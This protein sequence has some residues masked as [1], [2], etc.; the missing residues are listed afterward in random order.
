MLNYYRHMAIFTH[1]VDYGSISAASLALNLS[2]SVISQQLKSLEE[3][4]GVQLLQRTTRRQILTPAGQGFYR[5]CRSMLASSELAWSE[6][7]EAQNLPAGSIT[8]SAPHALIEGIIAPSIGELVSKYEKITPN[9][10]I[11]DKRVNL[12][13]DG[14]DLA[15]RV[16]QLP[17]SDYKQI[18]LG[19]FREVLCA[20]PKYISDNTIDITQLSALDYIANAWQ[21]KTIQHEAFHIHTGESQQFAFIANRFSN[22]LAA[23]VAMAKASTG[24]AFIPDFIFSQYEKEKQ[25]VN[26]LPNYTFPARPVYALHAFRNKTPTL[27]KLCIETLKSRFE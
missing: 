15:V 19:R 21:G 8:L 25:L 7:R 9:I 23:V 12:V 6:A 17:S 4:V 20:S 5:H 1:V 22:S 24:L 18:L 11:D 26:V 14:I 10:L 13:E 3:A 16:G 27:V 2:K